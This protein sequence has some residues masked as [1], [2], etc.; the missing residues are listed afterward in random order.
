MCDDI[1]LGNT[2][3]TPKKRMGGY[4]SNILSLLKNR[5]KLDYFADHF[6]QQ[7]NYSTSHTYIRKHMR[8]KVVNQ[9][10]N[11]GAMKILRHPIVTYVLR[12]I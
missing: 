1:Y 9:I 8:F 5:Q 12:N 2:Q 3:H 7:F 10:K 4:F 6:E 11:I